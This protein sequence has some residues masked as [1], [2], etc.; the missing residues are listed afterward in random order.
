MPSP[1]FKQC[2]APDGHEWTTIRERGD[3]SGHRVSECIHCGLLHEA[4]WKR[5][6]PLPDRYGVPVGG[7]RE[8]GA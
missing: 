1:G 3:F 6:H 2:T 5:D 7:L 8:A 4:R